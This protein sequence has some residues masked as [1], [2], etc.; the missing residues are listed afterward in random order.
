MLNTDAEGQQSFCDLLSYTIDKFKP[1][2]VVDAATLTGACVVALGHE[3][4]GLFSN[5]EEL[6]LELLQ[7]GENS[8]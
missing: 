6:A 3:Y 5:N 2:L 4:T 8:F 7:A 1:I